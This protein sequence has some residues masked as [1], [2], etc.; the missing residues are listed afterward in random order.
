MKWKNYIK[1]MN[2]ENIKNLETD[3]KILRKL[4]KSTVKIMQQCDELSKEIFSYIDLY[5][6]RKDDDKNTE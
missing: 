6:E 5:E 4:F 2:K 3:I 1:K